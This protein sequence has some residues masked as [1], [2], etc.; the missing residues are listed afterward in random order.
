MRKRLHKVRNLVKSQSDIRWKQIESLWKAAEM[1]TAGRR[2]DCVYSGLYLLGGSASFDPLPKIS[3]PLLI[4]INRFRG[5]ILTL[6]N[7]P[8]CKLQH[9]P[10]F[11]QVLIANCGRVMVWMSKPKTATESL[12]WPWT[13]ANSRFRNLASERVEFNAPPDTI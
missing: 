8:G 7:P 12:E 10:T 1:C 2:T 13:V 3:D 5:L 11:H 9:W 4:F 6:V